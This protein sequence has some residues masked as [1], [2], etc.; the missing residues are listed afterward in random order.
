MIK[1]IKLKKIV[2]FVV[3]FGMIFGIFY[4]KNFLFGNNIIKNR[5]SDTEDFL[6][7]VNNY[8]AD[9]SV[10][11]SSN[12]TENSYEM[13]QE[14]QDGYSMQEVKDG[15]RIEI[16]GNNLKVSN[17]QLKLEKVYEDYNGLMN[18]SLFLNCF[19][20]DYNDEMN[21][22]KCYEENGEK[23][24]EIKLSNNQNTYVKYKKLYMDSK[25]GLPTK[26][27]VK[28]NTK[29]ETICIIYNNIELK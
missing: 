24:F 11:V 17:T 1:A 29:K 18:N 16:N 6:S 27:E 15:V 28:D 21:E 2:F 19:V 7:S 9:V 4:Y 26:L 10:K 8:C 13:H 3:L 22:A 5:S 25:T 12:K 23:I 20:N 14:T